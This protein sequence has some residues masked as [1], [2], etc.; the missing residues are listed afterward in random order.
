M[1]EKFNFDTKKRASKAAKKRVAGKGKKSTANI[2]TKK[3]M[4]G[5]EGESPGK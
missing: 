2:S 5:K 3:I 1:R 4:K